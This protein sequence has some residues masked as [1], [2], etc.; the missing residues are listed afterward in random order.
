MPWIK[1]V[2]QQ[3]TKEI[4]GEEGPSSLFDRLIANEPDLYTAFRPLQKAVKETNLPEDL[5]EAVI[6]FV[7]MK[8]GCR[9]CTESHAA[10]LKEL[11]GVEHVE[12]WLEDF[13]ASSMSEQWKAVLEYAGRLTAK[14][15]QVDKESVDR[16]KEAGFDAREIAVI[17]HTVA[18]T[19]Y[20][21]QLSMG[22]GL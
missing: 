18:Y 19:S 14:P 21:N 7:S 6:T 13:E 11:T 9:Y 17:N 5:R 3:H 20:T 2:K 12:E 16:L 10:L 22:L 1:P 8:N 4:K 15:V